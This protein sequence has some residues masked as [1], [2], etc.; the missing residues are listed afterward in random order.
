M[1]RKISGPERRAL[2]GMAN[3][4]RLVAS[5][6][7]RLN[8]HYMLGVVDAVFAYYQLTSDGRGS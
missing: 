4:L 2:S 8:R 6:V 3:A 7:A 1:S 5:D